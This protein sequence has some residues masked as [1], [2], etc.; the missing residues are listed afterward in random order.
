[1]FLQRDAELRKRRL[2][3][4]DCRSLGSLR[5]GSGGC[6]SSRRRSRCSGGGGAD[7]RSRVALYSCT[8]GRTQLRCASFNLNY[9]ATAGE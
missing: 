6:R 2:V 5:N 3:V 9:R 8:R 1:M 7:G 4:F